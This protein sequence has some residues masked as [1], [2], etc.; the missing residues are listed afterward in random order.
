MTLKKEN[1]APDVVV[2]AA[3]G[4]HLCNSRDSIYV[5]LRSVYQMLPRPAMKKLPCRRLIRDQILS[6]RIQI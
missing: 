2:G 4:Q 6:L 3:T 5:T 1:A